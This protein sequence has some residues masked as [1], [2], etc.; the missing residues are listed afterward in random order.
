MVETGRRLLFEQR[1]GTLTF[2]ISWRGISCRSRG[3]TSSEFCRGTGQGCFRTSAEPEPK[4]KREEG[5]HRTLA[6]LWQWR[7]PKAWPQQGATTLH[8]RL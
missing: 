7:Q 8:P 5:N 1:E 3:S 2:F 6:S 4:R